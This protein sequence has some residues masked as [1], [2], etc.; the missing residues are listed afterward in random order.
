MRGSHVRNRQIAYCVGILLLFGLMYP[1]IDRLRAL[2][3]KQQLGEATIG[4]VDAGSF[5]LKLALLGGA[6]GVAANVLWG[7]ALDL[8]KV[9]DWDRLKVT[10][11]QITKLQP[12]FLRVWSWQGWNL[13]YNVSVEWDSPEDKYEWIK[14]G[15]NFLKSGVDHNRKSP[16][17]IWDT[18]WTY[19]QKIGTADEAIILRRL[20][21]DDD[22]IEYRSF[23]DPETG[24]RE[25]RD[26]NFLVAQGWFVKAVYLVEGGASR[27][28]ADIEAPVEYVDRVESR[29]GHAGDLHFRSMPASSLTKYA[30][31]LEK[32]SVLGIAP[33]FGER[34]RTEWANSRNAWVV[35][36]N[37][38]FPAPNR[39]V[40]KDV[41]Q[42]I[43][44]DDATDPAQ[45]A[46]RLAS[47]NLNK[48]QTANQW[49]W[50]DRWA[51]NTHYRYWK[52]RALAE[53]DS[54]GVESRRLFYEGTRAFKQADY[55]KAVEKFREGLA[56]WE[57]LLQEHA[58][59]RDDDLNKQDTGRVVKR[60]LRALANAGMDPPKPAPFEAMMKGTT[61]ENLPDPYDADDMQVAP[62][63]EDTASQ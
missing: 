42:Y 30:A 4:Q 34:A 43:Y 50:T 10:V 62:L 33:T 1:Y 2:K 38:A 26:D 51:D 18:A 47:L 37:H 20:F 45:Y 55:P 44:I 16:D 25:P 39:V 13:A 3:E 36:G 11:D 21:R 8:Q 29:K 54:R 52:D 58:T 56:R 12:H 35:F 48:E 31:A 7:R 41:Q 49:Y 57:T 32:A 6:R 63:G 22:D 23:V 9:H 19:Y 60:Y 15:I 53:M 46:R 61:I 24:R 14:Q 59:F 40:P 17:L 28:A 27:A 5:M